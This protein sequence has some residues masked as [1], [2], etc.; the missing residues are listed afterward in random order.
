MSLDLVQEKQH[1]DISQELR[2]LLLCREN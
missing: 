2:A 1:R